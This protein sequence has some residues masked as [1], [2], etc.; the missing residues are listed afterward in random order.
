[1]LER[2][3][4]VGGGF[5]DKALI[6]LVLALSLYTGAFIAENVRAGILAI[7]TRPDRGRRRA[8]P[9]RRTGS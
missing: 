2:F 1:M 5:V 6:A 4:F 8:R 3:N 7:S 9:A